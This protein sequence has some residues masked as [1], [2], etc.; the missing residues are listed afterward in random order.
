MKV[1]YEGI[2]LSEAEKAEYRRLRRGSFTPSMTLAEFDVRI[3]D[4][5]HDMQTYRRASTPHVHN[6]DVYLVEAGIVDL[7]EHEFCAPLTKHKHTM[8][9]ALKR[10]VSQETEMTS[11]AYRPRSRFNSVG[12]LRPKS[13]TTLETSA[14]SKPP[15]ETSSRQESATMMGN[16]RKAQTEETKMTSRGNA[17]AHQPRSRM[18]SEGLQRPKSGTSS[19]NSFSSNSR[20]QLE[21]LSGNELATMMGS[22]KRA[23]TGETEVTSRAGVAAHE[24]RSRMN[25]ESSPTPKPG[26]S[27]ETP[28]SCSPRT[29]SEASSLKGSADMKETPIR[30]NAEETNK[31]SRRHTTQHWPRSGMISD[32]SLS[33]KSDTSMQTPKDS[34]ANSKTHKSETVPNRAGNI[35]FEGRQTIQ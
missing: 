13:G 20:T 28:A 12:S 17:V 2:G 25:S 24:P 4:Y 35:Y 19:R 33:P 34:M 31:T 18:N 5:R 23:I 21:T 11:R 26:T 22:L 16:L 30:D 6:E 32:G 1:Q 9:E 3:T 14:P 15:S 8:K 7:E 10:A 29:H 27:L